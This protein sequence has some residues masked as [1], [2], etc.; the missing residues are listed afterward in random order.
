MWTLLLA[1]VG[2]ELKASAHFKMFIFVLNGSF[3]SCELC[4]SVWKAAKSAR[5]WCENAFLLNSMLLQ[6]KKRGV[7]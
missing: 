6:Q 5:T 1:S 4:C 3:F 7:V 2:T